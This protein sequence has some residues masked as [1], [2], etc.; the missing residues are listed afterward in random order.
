MATRLTL[1]AATALTLT[2]GT[3]FA[4]GETL[5][6]VVASVNGNAITMADVLAFKRQVGDRAAGIPDDQLMGIIIDQM[7]RQSV[8][9]A[10]VTQAPSWLEPTLMLQRQTMLAG[11]AITALSESPI[12]PAAVQERYDATFGTQGG[13]PEFNA[14]HILVNTSDEAVALIAELNDGAD[15]AELAKEHS[16]GPSGPNGGELGWFGEGMMVPAF[17]EA[18]KTLD[19]GEVTQEPVQTQFGFHVVKLNDSRTTQAPTLDSVRADIEG[20]L[21]SEALQAKVEELTQA[22]AVERTEGIDP[23]ALSTLSFE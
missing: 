10:T 2:A 20:Q 7:V 9:A 21:Q 5:D 14:S 17:E 23:S 22:A 6:T 16:T 4:E 3:A 13:A 18:A 15:F 11:E 19:V 8:L 12:D 1:W